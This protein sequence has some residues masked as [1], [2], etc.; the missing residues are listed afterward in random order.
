[1]YED[2]AKTQSLK[3]HYTSS[4]TNIPLFPLRGPKPTACPTNTPS[5]GQRT[6][7]LEPTPGQPLEK[8]G[9]HSHCDPLPP[10]QA[11]SEPLND[12]FSS[13]SQGGDR[14]DDARLPVFALEK[15][16]SGIVD[17]QSGRW[18]LPSSKIYKVGSSPVKVLPGRMT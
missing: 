10:G 5:T 16:L 15:G 3:S 7:L 13:P 17:F 2:H 9:C 12:W 8:G 6:L 14:S 1:M 11:I 18:F 4:F